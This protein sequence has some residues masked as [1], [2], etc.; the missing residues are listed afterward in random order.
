MSIGKVVNAGI[1]RLVKR[2]DP[3]AGGKTLQPGKCGASSHDDALILGVGAQDQDLGWG[4]L[5]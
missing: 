2:V 3:P 1:S 4:L 5:E